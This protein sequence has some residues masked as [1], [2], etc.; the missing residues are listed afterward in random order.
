MNKL[1]IHISENL[2][3][4]EIKFIESFLTKK[5]I[6]YLLVEKSKAKL[7]FEDKEF[8]NKL[9]PRNTFDFATLDVEYGGLIEKGWKPHHKID[10]VISPIIVVNFFETIYL[11]KPTNLNPDPKAAELILELLINKIRGNS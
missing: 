4:I 9:N 10:K 5:E 3:E 8:E 1:N 7:I 6:E 2:S 11:N